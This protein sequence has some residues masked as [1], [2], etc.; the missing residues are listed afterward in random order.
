[1]QRTADRVRITAQL[2][3][4]T[5]G[6]HVWSERYDRE[7][8]DIFDIQ[9]DITLEITKALEVELIEGEQAHIWQKDQTSNLAAY[10][11]FLQGHKYFGTWTKEGNARARELFN[12]AIALDPGYAAA[13]TYLGWTYWSD[14]RAGWSTSKAD[15]IEK[16]YKCAQKSLQLNPDYP[17]NHVLLGIVSTLQGQY[18]KAIEKIQ[19]ALSIE[20]NSAD[21]HAFL[22]GV[23]GLAGKWREGIGY[24]EKSIR[25][26]PRPNAFYNY[27]LG[28]A[29][30]MTGQYDEA[31]ESFKQAVHTGP[32]NFVYHAF[33]SA[34]YSSL[35]RQAEAAAEANELLRINPEFTLES[36]AKTLPY[37]NK[38]DIDRYIS[39]LRKAGLPE[40][41]PLPL[42]DKPSIAVLAFDN[43]TGDPAQEYFCDGIA[44]E[45]ITVLS[46]IDKM[47]V[48]AR[49]SSFSYKGKPVRIQQISEEL[50]VRYVL[51]GSVRRSGDNVRVTAQLIDAVKGQHIWAE[52][53]D[54]DFNDIFK[55]QDEISVRVVSSLQIELTEGEQVRILQ[56]KNMN[57]DVYKKFLRITSNWGK[58]SREGLE[59][60]GQL[61]QEIIDIDPQSVIGHR[62]LGW[63][64]YGLVMREISPRENVKKAFKYAQIT[65]SIDQDDGFAHSLLGFIYLLMKKY[66]EAISSGRRSVELQ[67]NGALAHLIF[68]S[69]LN[70]AGRFDEALVHLKQ[71]IR[72]NPFPHYFYYYHLGACYLMK[73]EFENALKEIKKV[74]QLVPD[75]PLG[76][77]FLAVNYTLLDRN[78]EARD[79][80]A[81][82][83]ELDPN[84]SVSFIRRVSKIQNQD[85]IQKI[86]DAMREA[87]FPE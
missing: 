4:A 57:S 41:P 24:S 28:R 2:I 86:L 19:Y 31:I 58:G 55:I 83:L 6:H 14:A 37:K 80:A 15:S 39:A 1:M 47:F 60:C 65:L 49:T 75:W 5:T 32:D 67:P 64:H 56:E 87:G 70:Y 78:E 8:K 52:S 40:T 73:D 63:Y 35:N 72:L 29:Y 53:Y 13:Y 85:H 10:E 84:L 61:A 30:F 33:L 18:E 9:D 25:L 81:K 74:V 59:R 54:R 45:I 50:G 44:Q 77:L 36:Y 79:S 11:K 17:Y 34:C 76:H 27:I 43:M 66:D 48:I 71:A 12:E 69:T 82:A 16:A 62:W 26:S 7:Q 51:E 21:Y 23:L 20:P 68:G 42:P 22:S 38:S 3:D 46:M